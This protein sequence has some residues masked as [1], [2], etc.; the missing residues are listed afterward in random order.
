MKYARTRMSMDWLSQLLVACLVITLLLSIRPTF[1]PEQAALITLGMTQQEVESLLGKPNSLLGYVFVPVQIARDND[2]F[3]DDMMFMPNHFPLGPG[4]TRYTLHSRQ[5]EC[6]T[7][8]SQGH[9][10][11]RCS[12]WL[13]EGYSIVV[14]YSP[15]YHAEKVYA[16]RTTV[17]HGDLWDYLKWRVRELFR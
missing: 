11:W 4:L 6:W 7:D 10:N 12:F 3:V 14:F 13:G 5:E 17:T 1:S 16:L 8:T 9:F 15:T 2:L